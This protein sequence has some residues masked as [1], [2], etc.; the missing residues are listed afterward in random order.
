MICLVIG[1]FISFKMKELNNFTEPYA[2]IS[3]AILEDETVILHEELIQMI[4]EKRVE[5]DS[6]IF[7]YYS[8]SNNLD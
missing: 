7:F 5:K 3:V 4:E 6:T 8:V 2:K 1:T